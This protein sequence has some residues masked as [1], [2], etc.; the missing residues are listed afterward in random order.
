MTVVLT[1]KSE[2]T[3]VSKE[4]QSELNGFTYG[5]LEQLGEV[6]TT[7][8][9]GTFVKD[10][11][12][13]LIPIISEPFPPIAFII[14]PVMVEIADSVSDEVGKLWDNFYKH[15][16]QLLDPIV[17][18]YTGSN[19]AEFKY[20]Q[21]Y[22]KKIFQLAEFEKAIST[23]LKNLPNDLKKIIIGIG[24]N[25]TKPKYKAKAFVIVMNTIN[26]MSKQIK[27][28]LDNG[29]EAIE[30]L[31]EAAESCNAAGNIE[32][33][34]KPR[35]I[36]HKP[37]PKYR[38]PPPK[39]RKPPPKYRKPPPK[40]RKPPPKYRKP[41]PKYRKPPPLLSPP[42]PDQSL[43]PPPPPLLSPPPPD[44]SSPPPPEQSLPPPLT[45]EFPPPPEQSLPPPLT[46]EFPPPPEQSLPP[47]LTEESPP[48]FEQSL[49][50]PPTE[51]S[52]PSPDEFDF[53]LAEYFSNIG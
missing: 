21:L 25:I 33:L 24:K 39:Y 44:Q 47:P 19:A 46:E 41:P 4:T 12:I 51:E 17:E 45:E 5:L 23:L 49:P 31:C 6:V 11:I 10:A 27:E 14:E 18:K 37:P 52:P 20:G 26:E 15:E 53:G 32:N 36:M 50:P 38:K 13:D 43:P 42:P 1:V 7:D 48:P 2:K 3:C 40:Y 22:A 34:C 30:S 29:K 35:F 16:I 8:T 28:S 9:T